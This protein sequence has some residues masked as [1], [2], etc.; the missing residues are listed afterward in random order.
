MRGLLDYSLKF[1]KLVWRFL[2]FLKQLVNVVSCSFFVLFLI[3]FFYFFVF[4]KKNIDSY[5]GAL[6]INLKGKIVDHISANSYT[7]KNIFRLFFL[8]KNKE[9]ISLFEIV[10]NIRK[11]ILDKKITGI[12]LKLDNLLDSD[13]TSLEYIGKALNEFKRSGKMIYSIGDNYTQS[14]YYLASF[15]NKIYMSPHGTVDIHGFSSNKFYYKEFLDKIKIKR[16]IFRIGKYKSAIEPLIRNNM[17]EDSRKSD[18]FIINALWSNYLSTVSRNRN[19]TNKILF[20]GSSELI[21]KLKIFKGNFAE[22][23]KNQNIVDGLFN[24]IDM[25]KKLISIFGRNKENNT[26]NHINIIDYKDVILKHKKEK[27]DDIKPNIAVI[28]VQGVMNWSDGNG[29]IGNQS[30]IEKIRKA[31]LDKNIKC[32]ILRIN[33]PGGSVYTA[34]KIRDELVDLRKAGK[35]IIVSMGGVAASAGYWISTPADYII[36]NSITITGSIGIF[37]LINTLEDTLSNIGIRTDGV[38]TET[39]ADVSIAKGLN[40]EFC[41]LM[42]INIQHGYNTFIKHVSNSRKKSF[43]EIE[44]I[45]QGKIWIGLDAVKN[46]LIDSLGDFDSAVDKAMRLCGIK[47][48]I[49]DWMIEKNSFFENLFLE[50]FS[51]LGLNRLSFPFYEKYF[52]S[53]NKNIYLFDKIYDPKNEYAFCLNCTDLN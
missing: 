46:G 26:F 24:E 52:F 19:I 49:I 3:C 34:E 14:Q 28:F 29:L 32:V 36:S 41:S 17:S 11:S 1:F 8:N 13:Q 12:V 44:K 22:Y 38:S 51:Y 50:F 10:E 4:Q 45:A 53:S 21:K 9:E 27:Y 15:S 23:V 6:L 37:G 48:P 35:T 16:H 31:K 42:K 18:Y 47:I 25:E 39:L 33:S 5:Q 20:P 30:V 2:L 7:D 40:E 43:K